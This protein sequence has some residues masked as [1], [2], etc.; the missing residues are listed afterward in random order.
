[1]SPSSI[2]TGAWSLVFSQ[3]CGALSTSAAISR[4]FALAFSSRWSMRSPALRSKALR[5]YFQKV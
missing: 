4:A 2:Q 3:P 1:L 5:Q